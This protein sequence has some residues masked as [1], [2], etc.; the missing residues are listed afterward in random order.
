MIQAGSVHTFL[1]AAGL[2]SG[3]LSQKWVLGACNMI[4]CGLKRGT[5]DQKKLRPEVVYPEDDIVIYALR[6]NCI[7]GRPP[8]DALQ[9]IVWDGPGTKEGHIPC[10]SAESEERWRVRRSQF[11]GTKNKLSRTTAVPA[12]RAQYNCQVGPC[13]TYEVAQDAIEVWRLSVSL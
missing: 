5:T 13:L 2:R 1:E 7:L 11:L 6:G 12:R 4:I 10:D 3:S 9:R 8:C